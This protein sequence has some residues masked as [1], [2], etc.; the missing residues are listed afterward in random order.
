[1]FTVVAGGYGQAEIEVRRSRFIGFLAPASTRGSAREIID[2][3]RRLYP[4]ARHHCS[5]YVLASAGATPSTHSSD[6]GEPSGTA[7]APMLE[8]LLGAGLVDVVAVVTRYFGG[9]LLGTGGLVRAYS[10]ATQ[11]AIGAAPLAR[12]ETLPT[13]TVQVDLASAGKVDAEIRQRDWLL[14]DASWGAQV[15]LT[16]SVPTGEEDAV[17]PFIAALT[18]GEGLLRRGEDRTRHIRL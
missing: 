14:E 4:D 18:R 3:Q 11:A 12:I 10:E 15:D 5:A 1:M 9:T 8:V 7:G 16:F 2:E 17:E 6:D 13:F